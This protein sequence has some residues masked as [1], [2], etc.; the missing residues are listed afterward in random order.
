MMER[1]QASGS[2]ARHARRDS[3][4]ASQNKSL[5]KWLQYRKAGSAAKLIIARITISG[6]NLAKRKPNE[7]HVRNMGADADRALETAIIER[8]TQQVAVA[9]AC[10]ADPNAACF[11]LHIAVFLGLVEIVDRLILAGADVNQPDEHGRTPLHQVATSSKPEAS[12][13]IILNLLAAGAAID[14]RD[15]TGMTPLER[16]RWAGN[17]SAERTLQNLRPDEIEK[18]RSWGKRVVDR[19]LGQSR[20]RDKQ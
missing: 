17:K 20:D 19:N 9:I 13:A 5:E 4:C 16:A 6:I 14:A 7:D 1:A 2:E 15:V 3:S 18:M 11:P 8:N 10:G 12:R